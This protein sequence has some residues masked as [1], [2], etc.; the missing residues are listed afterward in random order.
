MGINLG[1]SKLEVCNYIS[2]SS[3]L[4]VL[5]VMIMLHLDLK[6]PM[7]RLHVPYKDPRLRNEVIQYFL[8]KYVVTL[9]KKNQ[10]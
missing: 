6:S 7:K 3:L 9:A 8:H 10:R 1:T 5:S 2:R 4:L